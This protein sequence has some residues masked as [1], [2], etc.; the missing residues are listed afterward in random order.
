M[1]FLKIMALSVFLTTATAFANPCQGDAQ[2]ICPGLKGGEAASCLMKN[3]NS[4]SSEC[5]KFLGLSNSEVESLNNLESDMKNAKNENSS[6]RK[7]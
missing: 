7:V 5:K 3:R 1:N 4:L 2:K 6:R